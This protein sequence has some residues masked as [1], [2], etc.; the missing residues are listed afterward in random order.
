[1]RPNYI[2]LLLCLLS[3]H[4]LHAQETDIEE[5]IVRDTL[6]FDENDPANLV[7][8]GEI[9]EKSSSS[10]SHTKAFEFYSTAIKSDYASAYRKLADC[11]LNGLGTQKNSHKA[12]QLYHVAA[13]KGDEQA[14]SDLGKCFEIGIG[15]ERSMAKALKYYLLAS[16]AGVASGIYRLARLYEQGISKTQM[17]DSVGLPRNIHLA[18]QLYQQLDT[19]MVFPPL[20]PDP[21]YRLA[22]D[23][24]EAE[25]M[26]MMA[27]RDPYTKDAFLWL[28]DAAER[29]CSDAALELAYYYDYAY[30]PKINAKKALKNYILAAVLGNPE[31]EFELA[32]LYETGRL[33][34]EKDLEKALHWYQKAA[35]DG[36]GY[37]KQR[38]NELKTLTQ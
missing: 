21:I 2:C 4:V 5:Y 23:G 11:F 15:T 7:R 18:L 28:S 10:R 19:M 38:A 31:G 34:G 17:Q 26:Y 27:L 8:L 3:C 24:N 25:A 9:L 29:G 30:P 35:D 36:I 12:F 6:A 1:V 37:A 22:T 16:K 33:V 32:T 20:D 13:V 14:L